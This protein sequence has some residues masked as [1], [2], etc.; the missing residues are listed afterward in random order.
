[1]VVAGPTASGK[2]QL[3]LDLG[4][5]LDITIVCA[6]A[7]QAIRGMQIGTAAPTS[8]EVER[9]PHVGY[10][11]RDPEFDYSAAE[12][13]ETTR[14][15]IDEI[16]ETSIPVLVGGSGLYLQALFDGFSTDVVATPAEVRDRVQRMLDELGRLAFYDA[17]VSIDPVA[18]ERYADMNPRRVQRALE[19]YYTTQQRLSDT[20]SQPRRPAP[21]AVTWIGVD[22]TD[23]DLKTLIAQRCTRMWQQG[24]VDETQEL[25]NRGIDPSSHIMR[26]IGYAEAVDVINGISS[27]DD[28]R[29]RLLHSTW[30]YAK[31]QRTWFRRDNRYVWLRGDRMT[32]THE[33]HTLINTI[34]DAGRS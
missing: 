2:S 27:M 22:Q 34:R 33:A 16:P 29:Q 19:Y 3:A 12:Y 25:L 31:R 17:L 14:G 6:D 20:W 15:L 26:T 1:V 13:A 10:A 30:R 21:Y 8:D 23:T 28:A 11:I 7:R 9:I 18:A 5:V 4:E 24:L 32:I